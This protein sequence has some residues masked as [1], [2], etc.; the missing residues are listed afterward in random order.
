MNAASM[1]QHPRIAAAPASRHDA[2]IGAARS[3]D[4][5]TCLKAVVQHHEIRGGGIRWFGLRGDTL[6]A[7]AMQS[8]ESSGY[9][10]R[11]APLYR[12]AVQCGVVHDVPHALSAG[13]TTDA[14][15][16]TDEED[17]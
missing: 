10:F 1:P 11:L 13:L 16:L 4:P 15:A 6:E 8:S 3:A 5:A 12:L 14:D 9:R 17:A 7:R 2:T